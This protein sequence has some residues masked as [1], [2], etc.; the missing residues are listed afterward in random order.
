MSMSLQPFGFVAQHLV[1]EA[2]GKEKDV[3]MCRQ[4]SIRT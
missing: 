3:A 1:V 4:N 2:G